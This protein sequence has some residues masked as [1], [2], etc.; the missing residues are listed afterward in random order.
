MIDPAQPPQT[1][2]DLAYQGLKELIVLGELPRGTFL[3]QRMLAAKCGV[4]VVTVRGALR[5]LENDGLIENVPQWGVRIPEETEEAV[6]DRYFLRE[7]LEVAAVRRIVARRHE[8]D[9]AELTAKAAAC[10]TLSTEPG[11]DYK[12][13]AERHY[14][15]HQ[16]LTNLSGS[17]R[18]AE[19]YA[20]LWMRTVM[21]W[22]AERGWHRGYD[23]S[24]RLHQ[25]LTRAILEE[26]EET[27]VAAMV[28]HIRH[29]LELELAALKSRES[30]NIGSNWE[31]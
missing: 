6:R 31:L 23:R 20:R 14:A 16:A 30:K 29:G 7:I 13:Y 17:P 26:N 21:L 4:N 19:A 18:L 15:F 1:K 5:Q 8:I 3:S 10:D 24:P 28:E 11:D 27:A 22:N 25:D 9:P 2:E 12:K